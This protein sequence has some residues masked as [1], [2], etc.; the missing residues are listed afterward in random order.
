M[1]ILNGDRAHSVITD[2]EGRFRFR[3]VVPPY[4]LTVVDPNSWWERLI[5]FKGLT[6]AN[7][8]LSMSGAVE[9]FR[10][11][12]LLGA[13][14]G[15]GFPLPDGASIEVGLTQAESDIFLVTID[16]VTSFSTFAWEGPSSY[17]GSL[18]G[19]FTQRHPDG[20]LDFLKAGAITPF[21]IEEG[22]ERAV[23]LVLDRPVETETTTISADA[24]AYGSWWA[25]EFASFRIFGED[26][27]GRPHEVMPPLPELTTIPAEGARISLIGFLP[28]FRAAA[29]SI[30]DAVPGGET[31]LELPSE[32]VLDTLSP[33]PDAELATFT[34][35]LEWTPVQG[36]TSYVVEVEGGDT[37]SK[38]ILPPTVNFLELPDHGEGVFRLRS[39]RSYFWTVVAT[40]DAGHTP[41]ELADPDVTVRPRYW[42][43][44]RE[45]MAQ[46]SFS[47]E[48]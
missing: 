3:G 18:V 31:V 33:E 42:A 14:G 7:P 22:E 21:E 5:E 36:A 25:T 47:I 6:R 2:S 35:R 20:T 9:Y 27:P 4:D 12:T 13:I 46:G 43:G 30:V 26:F 19:V 32:I 29:V 28:G 16:E 44:S 34:P 39:G 8:A 1:V 37:F 40:M 15:V 23:D 11:A 48:P 17:S 10:L 38:W 45:Y 24:G 41:D